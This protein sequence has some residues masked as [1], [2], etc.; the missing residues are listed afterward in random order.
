MRVCL[1]GWLLSERVDSIVA[2]VRGAGAHTPDSRWALSTLTAAN[3]TGSA[4]VANDCVVSIFE[5][6]HAHRARW[7]SVEHSFTGVHAREESTECR[8]Q[9][10]LLAVQN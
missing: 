5:H 1:Y 8:D 3:V 9:L 6:T 7:V 2:L 4:S 10:R